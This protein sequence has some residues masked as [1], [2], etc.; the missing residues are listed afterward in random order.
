[1]DKML[2]PLIWMF[3]AWLLT[4]CVANPLQRSSLPAWMTQPPPSTDALFATGQG[5]SL[6]E[7]ERNARLSMA[8]QIRVQVSDQLN[9][10]TVLDGK[11]H[12]DYLDQTTSVNVSEVSLSQAA[13]MEQVQQGVD[14]FVLLRLERAPL[15]AQ[16]QHLIDA[17]LRGIERAMQERAGSP[18][19]HWWQ[20]RQQLPAAERA[21]DNLSLIQS[22]RAVQAAPAASGEATKPAPDPRDAQI[23]Q[24]LSAYVEALNASDRQLQFSFTDS[25]RVYGLAALMD[26]QLAAEQLRVAAR[27]SADTGEIELTTHDEV[28]QLGAEYHLTRTLDVRLKADRQVLSQTRLQAKVVSLGGRAQAILR[29]DQKLV[30]MAG[31]QNLVARLLAGEQSP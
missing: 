7:A 15:I 31:E 3:A 2:K 16:Q 12:R 30:A 23:R 25:S 6:Y 8:A 26:Q 5:I 13:V 9:I 22:L 21:W 27:T 20:L 11:F 19:L 18:F 4:A 1:M 17:D 14:W 28:R 29:A 24:R 10:R